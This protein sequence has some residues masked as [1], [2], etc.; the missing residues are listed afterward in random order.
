M[1]G[2][3]EEAIQSGVAADT[4]KVLGDIRGGTEW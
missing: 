3:S 4:E 2:G 1:K